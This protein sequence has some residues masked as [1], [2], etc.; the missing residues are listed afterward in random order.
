M[1]IPFWRPQQGNCSGNNGGWSI[2]N[3]FRPPWMS[4]RRIGIMNMSPTLFIVRDDSPW[5]TLKDLVDACKSKPNEY[6]Y[7]ASAYGSTH[8]PHLA[9]H[10]SRW[11]RGSPRFLCRR[12]A[13]PERPFGWTRPFFRSVSRFRHSSYARQKGE[14]SGRHCRKEMAKF[15]GGPNLQ[16]A[17]VRRSYGARG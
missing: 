6:I 16:G 12:G 14:G 1:G 10:G 13:C 5:K 8:Y 4:T 9:A 3:P 17:R 15:A 2:T 7:G 11:N